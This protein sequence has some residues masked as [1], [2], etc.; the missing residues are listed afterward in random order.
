MSATMDNDQATPETNMDDLSHLIA[1]A[2]DDQVSFDMIKRETGLSEPEVKALMRKNL[3]AG[4]YKVWRARVS[5]RKLKHAGKT[6][7]ATAK[8]EAIEDYSSADV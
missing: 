8:R 6:R 5:G 3:K 2:W 1:L 4:S 7:N